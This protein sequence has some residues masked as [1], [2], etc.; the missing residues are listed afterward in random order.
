[1][2]KLTSEEV[3][4]MMKGHGELFTTAKLK[5][6]DPAFGD[7]KKHIIEMDVYDGFAIGEFEGK[8]YYMEYPTLDF[9][10]KANNM[11]KNILEAIDKSDDVTYKITPLDILVVYNTMYC[12][13]EVHND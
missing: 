1:M 2:S 12:N 10:K 3:E 9:I 4:K 13:G 7:N 8:E 11:R 5:L 6:A